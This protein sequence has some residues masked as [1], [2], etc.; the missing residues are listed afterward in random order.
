MSGRERIRRLQQ[1]EAALQFALS[2]K[3]VQPELKLSPEQIEHLIAK[4][5]I[6]DNVLDALEHAER[7]FT[8]HGLRV[9]VSETARTSARDALNFKRPGQVQDTLIRLG[10]FWNDIRASGQR[11]DQVA[12]RLL[13]VPTAMR[14]S[15]KTMRLYGGQR[16]V[17]IGNDMVRL[18]KHLKLGGGGKGKSARIYFGDRDG[19]LLIGHVGHHLETASR[20]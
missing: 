19:E 5:P 7:I 15:K 12:K 8:S 2:A 11:P 16:W 4:Q 13:R 1:D 20:R 14:E 6:P 3:R 9:R 10:F 17:H 18:Q